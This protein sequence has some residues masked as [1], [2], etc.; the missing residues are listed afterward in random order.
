MLGADVIKSLPYPDNDIRISKSGLSSTELQTPVWTTSIMWHWKKMIKIIGDIDCYYCGMITLSWLPLVYYF[1]VSVII[2][3]I[4]VTGL[5]LPLSVYNDNIID[6]CYFESNSGCIQSD[7]GDKRYK[8]HIWG[9]SC[10]DYPLYVLISWIRFLACTNSFA[11]I[12][13]IL[14]PNDMLVCACTHD[15]IFDI[16]FLIQIFRY[17]CYC[18]CTPLFFN[19]RT[20][21][22]TLWQ[23]LDARFCMKR[24]RPFRGAYLRSENVVD[25]W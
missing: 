3:D 5:H 1:C 10:L 16:C 14:L 8:G 9:F 4:L 24:S 15:T 17:M 22:V 11:H 12:C 23:P 2:F 18:L 20:R 25:K 13:F 7:G 21:W 6:L 19:L